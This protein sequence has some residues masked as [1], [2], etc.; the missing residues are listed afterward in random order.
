MPDAVLNPIGY[1]ITLFSA[2]IYNEI[3]IFNFCGLNKNTKKFVNERLNEEL[4]DIK[5]TKDALLSDEDD[6][7][8]NND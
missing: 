4:K 1:I 7:T 6:S 8:F 2:L 3:I 5:K